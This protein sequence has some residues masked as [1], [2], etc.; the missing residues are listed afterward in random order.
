MIVFVYGTTGELIKIAPVLVRLR[1]RGAAVETWCTGQQADELVTMADALGVARPDVWLAE[2]YR[3]RPLS[4]PVELPVWAATVASRFAR[5][6]AAARRA[7]G[8]D[9]RPGLVVVHGDTFTT[10]VG[11][12]MGRLL[13]LPVAHI[14]AGMRSHDLRNPFPE[15]LNRRLVAKLARI[16]FAPGPVPVENLRGA[17]GTVVDT[18]ANTVR[19]SLDL[20]PDTVE[21]LP[22]ALPDRFGVV[23]LHRFELLQDRGAFVETMKVLA[24]R[25]S[26]VPLVFIDH[27]VTAAKI[28]EYG[29]DGLFDDTTFIRVPKLSYFAFVTLVRRS[30][31]AITDSGGLQQESS[32]MNHP[33]LVHRAVTESPEGLGRNVVLSKLDLQVLEAFLRDPQRYRTTDAEAGR[34]PSDIVVEHLAVQGY[35]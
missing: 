4:R 33:C 3:G 17:K 26:E 8:A 24:T 23:S 16:H 28:Q 5:R 6:Y 27:A 34:S 29:L 1:E 35:C 30:D 18:G 14:E 22:A 25:A 20:V 2:G 13:R 19:D 10:V 11:A 7:L 31:F 15:E 12:V 9:G 32:Y 21:G